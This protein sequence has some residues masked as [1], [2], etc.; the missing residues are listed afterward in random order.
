MHGKLFPMHQSH[1]A[2]EPVPFSD[3][4]KRDFLADL[5]EIRNDKNAVSSPPEAC[6]KRR[7]W[8]TGFEIDETGLTKDVRPIVDPDLNCVTLIFKP[9]FCRIVQEK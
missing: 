6:P 1:R 8:E 4:Q 2:T 7:L 9:F 5:A 3:R